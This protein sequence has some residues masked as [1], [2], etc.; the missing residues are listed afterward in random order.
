[1]QDLDVHA[2]LDDNV[3]VAVIYNGVVLQLNLA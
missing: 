3:D 2:T 1:M